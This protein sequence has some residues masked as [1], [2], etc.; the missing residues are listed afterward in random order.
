MTFLDANYS[1]LNNY[2]YD[3]K[4][5][6]NSALDWFSTPCRVVLGG[7]NA[8]VYSQTYEKEVSTCRKIATLFLSIIILPVATVSICCL[9]LKLSKFPCDWEK[10]II[11]DQSKLYSDVTRIFEDAYSKKEYSRA[12]QLYKL[13]PQIGFR[14]DIAENYVRS[15]IYN[16]CSFEEIQKD[17]AIMETNR[18]IE[19][20]QDAVVAQLA[21]ET[22]SFR[23]SGQN[24][25]FFIKN[26]IGSDLENY[27]NCIKKMFAEFL[28][29]DK[30]DSYSRNI[31][32][33]DLSYRLIVDLFKMKKEK[34]N[35]VLQHS[36]I[37]KQKAALVDI[38]FEQKPDHL[39]SIFLSDE[40]MQKMG[41]LL[42]NIRSCN[43]LRRSILDN[44]NDYLE[45]NMKADDKQKWKVIQDKF[46]Q[47]TE[48]YIKTST[49]L[50]S[51]LLLS[52]KV[53]L[54]INVFISKIENAST[55]ADLTAAIEK[56]NIELQEHLAVIMSAAVETST[57]EGINIELLLDLIRGRMRGETYSFVKELQNIFITKSESDLKLSQV[58]PN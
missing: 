40:S 36:E 44:L 20:I 23:V 47:F 46:N 42:D 1:Y 45:Q 50:E 39:H 18:A 53:F 21:K 26:S 17:I 57:I 49:E 5:F 25:I 52:Q 29:V 11:V 54:T 9:I 56:L 41:I 19:L 35:S 7:K 3:G 58:V 33:M 8:C 24:I 13:T 55:P 2:N 51:D 37:E 31:Q 28:H 32:N 14:Q 34:S 27:E 12:I 22:K 15:K 38:L 48:S 4:S 10:K 30:R 16:G 6:L 43:Q